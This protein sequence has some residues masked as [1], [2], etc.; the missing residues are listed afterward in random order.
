[1]SESR[2][3]PE[4]QGII[5][6]A[7]HDSARSTRETPR[8]PTAELFAERNLRRRVAWGL[9]LSFGAA[10][11]P[12][13]FFIVDKA[14]RLALVYTGS[15]GETVLLGASLVA[16]VGVPVGTWISAR[17]LVRMGFR[18]NKFLGILSIFVWL[19]AWW[20]WLFSCLMVVVFVTFGRGGWGFG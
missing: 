1:M 15:W 10:A 4:N 18:K 14:F 2:M 16:V 12:V 20:H 19:I 9:L 3:H 5:A 8:V 11:L 13:L 6:A 7:G 17:N